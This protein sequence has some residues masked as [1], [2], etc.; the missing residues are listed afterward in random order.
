MCEDLPWCKLVVRI[1]WCPGQDTGPRAHGLWG[2]AFDRPVLHEMQHDIET[3]ESR[4][5]PDTITYGWAVFHN[6]MLLSFLCWEKFALARFALVAWAGTRLA[7]TWRLVIWRGLGTAM[8][9]LWLTRMAFHILQESCRSW[10]ASTAVG[11]S[12][13]TPIWRAREMMLRKRPRIWRRSW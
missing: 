12:S 4:R 1:S 11:C 2:L 9:R 10:C 8:M 6:C 3:T 13:P 5:Y 7:P